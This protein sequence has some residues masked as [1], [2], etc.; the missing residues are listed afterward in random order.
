MPQGHGGG[1]LGGGLG[2][3]DAYVLALGLGEGG[4]QG[5]LEVAHGGLGGGAA[6]RLGGGVAQ[7]GQHPGLV[8]LGEQH[9]LVGHLGGGP[10]RCR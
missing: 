4:G 5:A 10:S 8:D 3:F 9:Q 7:D 1:H 6:G 2:Q